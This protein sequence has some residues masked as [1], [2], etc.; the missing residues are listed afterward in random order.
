MSSPRTLYEWFARSAAQFGDCTALEV[1][2]EQVTYRELRNLAEQLAARLVAANEGA[3]PRRVGLL[4]GRSLAGYVGYLAILRTGAAVVPLN[5]DF[6]VARN[7]AVAAGAGVDVIVTDGS[8][9]AS[10][11]G[12]PLLMADPEELS[13]PSA[14]PLTAPCPAAPDDVAYILFTS[15]S[16]GAPKGVP[17]LHRNVGAYLSHAVRRYEVGPGSRLS[18]S[19]DLTFDGS[20]HDLFVAWGSGGTLVVPR[21]AQLLAPVTF[22]NAVRLTHWFSVPSV[23]SFAAR[24]DTLQPD[25]MPTLRWSLFGGEPLPLALAQAWQA[26]APNGTLENVYGPTE[27]TIT[28]TAYELPRTPEDCPRP[29][30]GTVP[31][32]TCHPSV[33][34]RVLDENG[35]PGTEGEL[36]LR[37]PQRFPGYLDASNDHG[38]F[39]SFDRD[40][41]AHRHTAGVPLTDQHWY[42][43]G[44]RVA[45]QD[46]QLVHLGRL[47]HQVSI[48]GY[49]IELGEIEAQLR[50][51]TGVH[52]AIVLAVEG[53]DG[54]KELE[55]AISGNIEGTEPVHAALRDCLPSYMRPRRITVFDTLPLNPN[56]KIDHHALA[57]S[58]GARH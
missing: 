36:C 39:G 3:A 37:G 45:L 7:A 29:A 55:A 56:G 33:E 11:L 31:I 2:H 9:G 52:D 25:S 6:P 21:R 20:V 24:L 43:T 14:E 19:F 1:D 41:V 49:R 26:A 12:L 40:G 57:A 35:E 51:Q 58:L 47:D 17:I 46:G 27:T 50:E 44:D 42:R 10:D 16:T 15:G 48:R 18:Q 28:C 23:A 54:E 4:A 30:N 34:F 32:G 53:S 13:E 5:P 38:R 8:S 22:V